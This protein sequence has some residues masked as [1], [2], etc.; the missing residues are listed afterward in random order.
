MTSVVPP[1]ECR[2]CKNV[3]VF[4]VSTK[5]YDGTHTTY[6]ACKEHARQ[7]D[8]DQ[9]VEIVVTRMNTEPK[10][11]NRSRLLC[12]YADDEAAG[13]AGLAKGDLW[14]TYDSRVHEKK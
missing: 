7:V 6:Y 14:C 3:C 4:H 2:L 10:K 1:K 13:K 5:E 8:V 11:Q 9:F 12:F